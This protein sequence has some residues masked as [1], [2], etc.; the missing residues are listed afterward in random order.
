MRQ[1]GGIDT[2]RWNKIASARYP[3]VRDPPYAFSKT[4]QVSMPNDGE[5]LTL[6]HLP[7]QSLYLRCMDKNRRGGIITMF[8]SM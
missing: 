5:R 1:A 8:L 6:F 2:D 7:A 3:S 4:L